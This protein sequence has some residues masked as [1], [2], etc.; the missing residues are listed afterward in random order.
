MNRVL[1]LTGLIL[2]MAMVSFAQDLKGEKEPTEKDKTEA[3]PTNA[4]LKRGAPEF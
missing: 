3:I 1:L 4:Y 2:T